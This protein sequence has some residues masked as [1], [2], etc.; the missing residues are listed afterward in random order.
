MDYIN[1][2]AF[3][4]KGVK[5]LSL[6]ERNSVSIKGKHFN[7]YGSYFSIDSFKEM[8]NRLGEELNL[9]TGVIK[10]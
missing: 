7:N 2:Q 1:W 10:I 9:T 4:Y 3:T 6:E 8:Y 5:F